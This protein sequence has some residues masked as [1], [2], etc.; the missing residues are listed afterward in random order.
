MNFATAAPCTESGGT[1]RKKKP[2][3]WP[4]V[5]RVVRV[6]EPET[7]ARPAFLIVGVFAIT[8]FE[9]AGPTRARTFE[10]DA[11]VCAALTASAVPPGPARSGSPENAL[12]FAFF[13]DLLLRAGLEL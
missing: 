3:R 13:W 11:T 7:K 5:V 12:N 1:V 2:V 4:S 9:P 10:F 6:A 8:S